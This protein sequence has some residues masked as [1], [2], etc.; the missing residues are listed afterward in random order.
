MIKENI[1]EIHRRISLIC[2]GAGRD[3]GSVAIVAVSKGRDIPSIEEALRCGITHIGENKVQEALSKH[4][5]LLTMDQACL[6]DRQGLST[7]TWHMIG[8][9]QTNKV[10]DAVRIFDL[11]ESVD[12]LH[13]AQAIDRQ[14]ARIHKI[15][16]ILV[17]VNTAND[18]SKFGVKPEE[19]LKTVQEISRLGNI[20]VKGLMMI[21]PVV[22]DPEKAR[23]Y[24]VQLRKLMNDINENNET[25]DIN[26]PHRLTILSMGMSAD[27]EPAIQEGATQVRIGRAL[28]DTS[29]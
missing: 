17:E 8:H 4:K 18:K 14:A 12:S 5:S 1:V 23:P 19:A 27:F 6:P 21:A 26:A 25:N 24:F 3:P 7:I 16:D 28:F 15:Q 29:T 2:S 11:I 22:D 9:L 13:L 20:R 10:K